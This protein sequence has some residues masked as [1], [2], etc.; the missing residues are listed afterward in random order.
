M[1]SAGWHCYCLRSFPYRV[2]EWVAWWANR[3]VSKIERFKNRKFKSIFKITIGK[4]TVFTNLKVFEFLDDYSVIFCWL[5]LWLYCWFLSWLFRRLFR[6]FFWWFFWCTL[7]IR[8]IIKKNYQN[9]HLKR[10]L[11]CWFFWWL[12][13][14]LFVDVSRRVTSVGLAAG[15]WR[16]AH[17]PH[18][19]VRRNAHVSRATRI[20]SD[21]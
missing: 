12:N 20:L 11:F 14:W 1:H 6:N 3:W 4:S 9:N 16:Q 21:I 8:K 17:L 10:W 19:H 2:S 18:Q 5:F 7:F 15:R 13:S